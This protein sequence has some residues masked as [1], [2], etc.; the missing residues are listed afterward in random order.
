M[1]LLRSSTIGLFL[2]LRLSLVIYAQ[3]ITSGE[4]AGNQ[5]L[6]NLSGFVRAGLYSGIDHGDRNKP[7]V[8][9][10]FSDL[11][12]MMEAGN[13]LN[14]K[15]F[16]DMRF[17][18]GAEFLEPVSFLD[19]K[20]AWVR[21][22]GKKW[23]LSA[24]QKI[25]KWGKADFTSTNSRLSPQNLLSRSPD[26]E[27]IDMGNLLSSFNWYPS[28]NINIEAVAVPYYKSSVLIIDPIPLPENVTIDQI[29]SLVTDKEMFSYGFRAD[30][31][32]SNIDWAL[33]WYDGYDPMAGISLS[34]FRLDMTGP[35]PSTYTELK[36]TPYKT[37]ALGLDFETTL[38]SFGLRGEAAWS[39]PHL[40]SLVDEHVPLPELKWVIGTDC[41]TGNWRIAGEYSGKRVNHF[42]EPDVQPLIG[43]EPD[44]Q[45]LAQLMADPGFNLPEY[46]RQQVGSFN[47]LYNYQ[48]ER[49][50]HSGALRIETDFAYGKLMPSVL[51]IYNFTSHDFLLLPELRFK[52]T[53]GLTITAGAEYYSGIKGSLY[54]ITDDFMN[55]VYISIRVD[56]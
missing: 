46:V 35:I 39:D 40:S 56:F 52:P 44:Y 24:G 54:D 31:H 36:M 8:S 9:S 55:S 37:R 5:K 41:S 49:Y 2:I 48:L 26:R 4:S 34:D 22:Y 32:L 13:G 33:S 45:L 14:F 7:Y 18:Y 50:Y 51:S 53:D 23:D 30:I 19:L 43:S 16:A 15:A 1:I 3:E 47:R 28:E 38:G 21:F 25:I 6:I 27:D 29:R 12:V 20:E 17:R 11:G 42:T 10:A